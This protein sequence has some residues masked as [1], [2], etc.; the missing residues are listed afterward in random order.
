MG[1][2]T[3]TALHSLV[4]QIEKDLMERGYAVKTFLDIEGA[5]NNTSHE[6]VCREATLRGVPHRLVQSI[7]GMLRRQVVTTLGAVSV[8]GWMDRGC[9]QGGVLFSLLWD[10]RLTPAVSVKYLGVI[11]DRKLTWKEHL[12]D[13]CKSVTSYFWLCRRYF[14]QTWGLRSGM[15]YWIYTAILRPSLLY[16]AVLWWP[17]VQ[18]A[19]AKISLEHLRALILRGALGAMRTTP[20]AAMGVL[21]G[22][23]P[24]CHTVV[25]AAASAAYRLS[26]VGKWRAGT[27]HTKLPDGVLSHP[28][29]SM[30]QDKM[31]AIR[32]L[33]A[34][35]KVCFPEREDWLRPQGPVLKNGLILFTDGSRIGLGSGAGVYC[36]GE[37]ISESIPLGEFATVFQAEIVTILCCAQGFLANKERGQ[38]ISICLNSQAALRALGAPITTFK[39]VW[40]CR[41]TLEE[42]ARDNEGNE[43][44]DQLARAGSET[45]LVGPEP[46]VGIPHSL[47]KREIGRWLRNQHL[48]SWKSAAGCRQAKALLGD[49]LREGLASGIKKLSRREAGLV[50]RI[51]TGHGTLNYHLQK[52]DISMR[53]NCRK[54][55][56]PEETSLHVLCDCPAYTSVKLELLGSAFLE[57]QQ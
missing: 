3:E 20:I 39:L 44:A 15:G 49:S 2:S 4:S 12:D 48:A 18:L 30:G 46:A 5:F 31:P 1:Y 35:F 26:C 9:P 52:L 40:E 51:L 38:R 45:A 27:R 21:L 41:G 32:A 7:R 57:S 34:P 16:A 50:T 37:E 14:G 11:L 47:G 56:A 8:G 29:F 13:R 22:I 54:C 43:A 55:N 25:A 6:V 42:L 19:S 24:L 28:I 10:T 23:E 33:K 36:R 17:R 53:P